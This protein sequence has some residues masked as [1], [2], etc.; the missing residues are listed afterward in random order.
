VSALHADMPVADD[1][2][3]GRATF[4][5]LELV[6][7]AKRDPAARERLLETFRPLIA[8]VARTY[9][10]STSV[11]RAELMQDGAVGLLRA[12]ERYDPTLGTPFW[13][14]AGWWVRQAMQQLVSE[15]MRP[16]VLSD[17]AV[18]QLARVK[19]ARSRL[20]Q[21]NG[22][23]PSLADLAV[24]TGLARDH[25]DHL[26][27]AERWPRALEEPL[28]GDHGDIGSLGDLV[29]DPCAEDAYE[30]ATWR[31]Q[32]EELP[33]LLEALSDRERAVVG[34][35]YGLDGPVL[36]LREIADRL[37]VSAER[38]RQIEQA[39]LDRLREEAGN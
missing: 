24:S 34:G 33:R 22:K 13:A 12:L 25:I 5:E 8:S 19:A 16:V 14:Y 31:A 36:T 27:A 20:A 21:A 10:R 35:H 32:L 2:P 9:A 38:V 7:A 4:C 15:L 3:P 29:A 1:A 28:D 39:A 26:V 17:R 37:G 6:V 18:R 23:E 11:H 30:D